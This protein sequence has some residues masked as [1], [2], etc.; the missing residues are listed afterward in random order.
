MH[1]VGKRA[2]VYNG[3]M[4]KKQK[5]ILI[6]EDDPTQ[7]RALEAIF[8]NKGYIVHTAEN[9]LDGF[10]TAKTKT[11][12]IILLDTVMPVMDG[13]AAL[14]KINSDDATKHIPVIVLTNFALHEKIY[15]FMNH[16]KD[17]FLTK[18][19]APL[20]DIVLKVNTILS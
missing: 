3:G 4:A 2:C 16:D 1:M 17:Y 11:P 19:S 10:E 14:E 9:G 18:T 13:I 12:D 5:V 7:L 15:P 20:K 6:I 8:H